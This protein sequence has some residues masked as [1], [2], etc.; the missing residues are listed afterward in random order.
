MTY[1]LICLAGSMA[2]A[3]GPALRQAE[4]SPFVRRTPELRP[5]AD[6]TLVAWARPAN[7]TQRGGSVLTLERS[8]SFDAIVFGELKPG[9]WMGGSE[10]FRRTQQDQAVYPSEER[11]G[12][13]FIRMAAVYRGGHITLYRDDAVAADYDAP[14]ESVSFGSGTQALIGLRHRARQGQS[15]SYFAGEVDE[16]RLYDRALTASQIASL[17]PADATGVRPLARWTFDDGT[18]RDAEGTFPPGA[19]HGGARVRGGRLI[20]NGKDA[21]MSTP[22]GVQWRNAFHFRPPTGN[23]ADP[24][25]FFWKGE[26]HVFYLQGDAGPVPWQHIVSKDLVHWTELPTAL[27]S[28]GAPDSPDGGHMFTG[29]V[30]EHAGTFHIFYTGHNPANPKAL[31]V[32]RH[33]TSKDLIRWTK[34]PDFEIGPDGTHYAAK[35][36][37]NW[38]DPFVF[39]N[40]EEGKWWMVV[41]ATD[42]EQP[43]GDNEFGRGVQGL[44]VSDDLRTWS[45]RPPLPGG[46]GEECPDLF[47]IGDTWYLLG[48]GRYVSGPAPGGPFTLPRHHVIDFPGVYAGKRMFDGR[49]HIWVGWAWDGPRHTDEA[50]AG[51]GVLSWGGFMCM[52]RELYAGGDGELYCRPAQ[53][54]VELHSKRL[55]SASASEP[56]ALSLPSDG[57]VECV[58]TIKPGADL[59]LSIR[60]QPDGRAYRLIVKPAEGRLTFATPASEW[61]RDG[62]RLDA[63]KPISLRVF[64]DG[65]I[66]ECFVNDAYAF[67][68][69][70]YDL[71]G[72]FARVTSSGALKVE[73]FELKVSATAK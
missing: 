54:I 41:I 28:D 30:M 71:D 8:D 63:S 43:G 27:V 61:H 53:E 68:R 67:T 46:L 22:A 35:R 13:G 9:A 26:Y 59:T 42:P 7:V 58:A 32:L 69:R 31:E 55:A 4:A 44:L 36:F 38:R 73:R 23:F 20:L 2:M 39:R 14:G 19:L 70:V 5:I 12:R 11:P 62:C 57:M 16:A 47:R 65:S 24:I 25:P 60:E 51:H 15:D 56:T 37:R 45:Q 3:L 49:R 33:A 17:R 48:G 10:M 52:P 21:F 40:E 66:M 18:C 72:G 64:T 6:K 1:L 29:C 50:V 34:D